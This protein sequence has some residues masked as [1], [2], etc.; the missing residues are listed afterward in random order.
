M[1]SRC[2]RASSTRSSATLPS[3]R[4]RLAAVTGS[5][6]RLNFL[7]PA[8]DPFPLDFVS[9]C[10][11]ILRLEAKGEGRSSCSLLSFGLLQLW[12]SVGCRLSL[13][14]APAAEQAVAQVTF[15][16]VALLREQLPRFC[17]RAWWCALRRGTPGRFWGTPWGVAGARS[18]ALPGRCPGRCPGQ[19]L[20]KNGATQPQ[21]R[22]RPGEE[23]GAVLG[24]SGAHSG[25]IWGAPREAAGA[26]TGAA[27][28]AD[29]GRSAVAA[30]GAGERSGPG[31]RSC[32]G[33]AAGAAPG[34]TGASLGRALGRLPGSVPG[35]APGAPRAHPDTKP[36]L[37]LG[38]AWAPHRKR[39]GRAPVWFRGALALG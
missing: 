30:G 19:G 14:A 36:R 6:F 4:R 33:L 11:M 29:L 7:C 37:P 21:T 26:R 5:L 16:A 10:S 13:R 35:C 17:R 39:P 24:R 15:L 1:G 34:H 18:G 25:R 9:L 38:W 28:R 12:L 31:T 8:H 23:A 3:C 32:P 2:G 22:S 27:P 20:C